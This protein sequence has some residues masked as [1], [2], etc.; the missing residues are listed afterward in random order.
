[1]ENVDLL[2]NLMRAFDKNIG[3]LEKTQLM[4]CGATIGQCHAI[5]EIGL[6]GEISLI[7]L[8]NVLNLDKSTMSR[9]VNNLVADHWVERIIDPNNRR[10]VKLMLST[11]GQVLNEQISAVLNAYFGKIMNDIPENKREQVT[12]SL[13]LLIY[14]LNKNNCC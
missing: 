11:K 4:C 1:M 10:Y 2:R 6:A 13:E 7:D 9:T 8:A 12:E 5:M 3:A 14:A